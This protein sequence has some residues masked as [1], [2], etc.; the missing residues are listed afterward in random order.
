MKAL[1]SSQVESTLTSLEGRATE[2]DSKYKVGP[3]GASDQFT[4]PVS[5]VMFMRNPLY[6]MLSDA[7]AAD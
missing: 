7:L 6:A 1:D 4:E 3:F 2:D 5:G